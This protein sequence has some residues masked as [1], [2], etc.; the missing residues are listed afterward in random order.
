MA[1]QLVTPSATDQLWD[2]WPYLSH[3]ERLK[4]FR[5]MHTGEKADFF[6]ALSPHDQ[7]FILF[8]L[9]E[10]QRHVWLRILPPDDA[11]DLIQE[12]GPEWRDKLL[13]LLDEPTRREVF[14]LLAYKDDEAGGL[15]NPRFARLRPDITADVAIS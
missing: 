10:E 7:A 9:P 14:A 8:G 3:A 2:R 5:E 11:A 12:A 6:L 13:A 1:T 15:M 4:Q